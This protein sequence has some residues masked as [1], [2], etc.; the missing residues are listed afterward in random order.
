MLSLLSRWLRGRSMVLRKLDGL[1]LREKKLVV[2]APP[3]CQ[4]FP[5]RWQLWRFRAGEEVQGRLL[6]RPCNMSFRKLLSQ[7]VSCLV[8]QQQSCLLLKQDDW[9]HCHLASTAFCL[10]EPVGAADPSTS[11]LL[12]FLPSPERGKEAVRPA[13]LCVSLPS[14]KPHSLG[15]SL[16]FS[17]CFHRSARCPSPA[18]LLVALHR[19]PTRVLLQPYT[20]VLLRED[21]KGWGSSEFPQRQSW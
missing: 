7:E 19:C 13:G 16:G 10:L 5:L 8:K 17:Q 21:R 12:P 11:T 14:A 15:R 9:R 1:M 4:I 2:E 6:A 20:A 18:S 3:S